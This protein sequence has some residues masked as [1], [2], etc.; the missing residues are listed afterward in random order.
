MASCIIIY[1]VSKTYRMSESTSIKMNDDA[2]LIPMSQP[3]FFFFFFF[4]FVP[5]LSIIWGSRYRFSPFP[6]LCSV[7]YVVFVT[8]S[9]A[10][11]MPLLQA[12]STVGVTRIYILF[13]VGPTC[14]SAHTTL[15]AVCSSPILITWP[16]NVF[17]IFCWA[18]VGLL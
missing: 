16:K 1:A 3:L 14:N 2:I 17:L 13:L 5:G 4:F 6:P 9:S 7:R 15:L 12:S 8:F 18:L 10:I 11:C